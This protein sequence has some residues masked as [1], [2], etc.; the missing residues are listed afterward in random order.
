MTSQTL[1][2]TQQAGNK[3]LPYN[4]GSNN[5]DH[6]G[7]NW[8]AGSSSVISSNVAGEVRTTVTVNPLEKI[9]DKIL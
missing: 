4:S 7:L 5:S 6:K 2:K 8:L 9:H 1:C 3:I